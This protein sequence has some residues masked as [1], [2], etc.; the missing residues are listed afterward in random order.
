MVYFYPK[1]QTAS[2]LFFKA[3]YASLNGAAAFGFASLALGHFNTQICL[4]I[5]DT[6]SWSSSVSYCLPTASSIKYSKNADAF[7][8]DHFGNELSDPFLNFSAGVAGILS[9]YFAKESYRHVRD[10][11]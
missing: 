5:K 7:S 3:C 9:I 4:N 6:A 10:I 8:R 11:F 2:D 1:Q